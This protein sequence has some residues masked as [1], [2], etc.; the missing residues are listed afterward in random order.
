MGLCFERLRIEP[1]AAECYKYIVE[2]NKRPEFRWRKMPQSVAN[3]VQMAAWR[4]DQLDWD[5]KFRS[6]LR[7][8]AG[9]DLNRPL[10]KGLRP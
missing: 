6:K 10:P 1:R 9:S 7:A 3:L 5:S 4:V 8:V 2:E